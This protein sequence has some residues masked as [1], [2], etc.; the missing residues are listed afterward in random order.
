MPAIIKK[1]VV[2]AGGTLS[3]NDFG[4]RADISSYT[5]LENAFVCPCDGYVTIAQWLS[6]ATSAN[7]VL[8]NVYGANSN[9]VINMRVWNYLDVQSLYVK[10]GMRCVFNS[11]SS[12]GAATFTPII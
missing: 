4:E 9:P 5:T 1:N 2:Y 12:N 10:K 11:A 6:S 7:T 3:K 8:L